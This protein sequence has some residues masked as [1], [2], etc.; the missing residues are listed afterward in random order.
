MSTLTKAIGLAIPAAVFLVWSGAAWRR[1]HTF[2]TLL[3]VIAAVCLLVVVLTHVAEARG[4]FRTMRWGQPDSAGHYVDL[5][6]AILAASL[7]AVSVL[8]DFRRSHHASSPS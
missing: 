4:W 3:R 8:V 1:S 2:S 7:F 5:A 6:S